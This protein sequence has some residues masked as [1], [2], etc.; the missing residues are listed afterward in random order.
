MKGNLI[1]NLKVKNSIF[2]NWK[3]LSLLYVKTLKLVK[4]SGK[5][6]KKTDIIKVKDK[7]PKK[8]FFY[9]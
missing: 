5:T 2:K 9:Y 4:K 1:K 3:I 8:D 6:R 7:S